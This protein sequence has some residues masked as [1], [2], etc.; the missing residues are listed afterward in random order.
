VTSS[1]VDHLATTIPM[2][3]CGVATASRFS[4]RSQPVLLLPAAIS[5]V[6]IS[7]GYWILLDASKSAWIWVTF[8]TLFGFGVGLML[9]HVFYWGASDIEYVDTQ[10]TAMLNQTLEKVGEA[11]TLPT[12]FGAW[13]EHVVGINVA[14]AHFLFSNMFHRILLRSANTDGETNVAADIESILGGGASTWAKGS[15]F[16][17][18]TTDSID[19]LSRALKAIFV[20]V[21]VISTVAMLLRIFLWIWTWINQMR[22]SGL[23]QE[24]MSARKRL[25]K[26][27]AFQEWVRMS[28]G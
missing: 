1:A 22:R 21:A 18:S 7:A 10:S 28:N 8:Q 14:T 2:I 11:K 16:P 13:G 20:Y 6:A 15:A 23:E 26:Y 17:S 12:Y 9:P 3:G 27:M 5:L 19:I 25:H 24:C 4:N